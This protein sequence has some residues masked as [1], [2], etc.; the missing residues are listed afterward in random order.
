[1]TGLVPGREMSSEKTELFIDAKG[2]KCAKMLIQ[3]R[4]QIIDLPAEQVILI[5]STDPVSQIDIPAWCHFLG[6]DH[7][8]QEEEPE[9]VFRHRVRLSGNTKKSD[10]HTPWHRS[11]DT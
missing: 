11:K 5:E 6:H 8:S 9:G 4:N 7:L 1:M 2:K 10:P 3:I